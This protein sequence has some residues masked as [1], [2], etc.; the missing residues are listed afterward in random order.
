V[1][2]NAMPLSR[3]GKKQVLIAVV[4][5]LSV[6][7]VVTCVLV[8]IRIFTDSEKEILKVIILASNFWY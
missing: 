2:G 6:V 3:I 5:I 1:N 8:G 4:A 7:L